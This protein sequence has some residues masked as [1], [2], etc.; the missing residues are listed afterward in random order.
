MCDLPNVYDVRMPVNA[1]RRRTVA[2]VA[3][4]EPLREAV[5]RRL[6]DLVGS[7]DVRPGEPITEAELVTAFGVSR[8]PV[9]EALLRLQAE[10]VLVS[11]PARGFTLRP[12]SASECDELYLVLGPLEALA[13]RSLPRPLDATRAAAAEQAL[14]ATADL[15]AQWRIDA[16]FHEEV[17]A[18][19]PNTVLRETLANLRMRLARYEMAYMT[20]VGG[21]ES[22][23]V[24]HDD[25]LAAMAA[26]DV[27]GT[28]R[29]VLANRETAR[30]AIVEWLRAQFP[31][32]P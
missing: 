25:I 4:P 9:R 1:S 19:C 11:T 12:L 22:M 3:R 7:G 20:R 18:G 8:T 5:Y 2:P 27:E 26:D 23:A 21:G 31:E 24:E 32:V 14:H 13:V 28:A 17:T 6:V 15:L 10:G 30:A 29:G 16:S